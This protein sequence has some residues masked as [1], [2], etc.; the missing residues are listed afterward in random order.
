M[1]T[2]VWSRIW[3]VPFLILAPLGGCRSD[4]PRPGGVLDD[5]ALEPFRSDLAA[6]ARR[7]LDLACPPAA[8]VPNGSPE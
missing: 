2:T 1:S 5:P 7:T 8:A 4:A 3:L 6:L